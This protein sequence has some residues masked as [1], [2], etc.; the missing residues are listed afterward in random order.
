VVR[1]GTLPSVAALV[2]SLPILSLRNG[3]P[4][5]LTQ[6]PAVRT[7]SSAD[8]LTRV[9]YQR[10][11]TALDTGMTLGNLVPNARAWFL[12]FD[13]ELARR[14]R[15]RTL[16]ARLAV[17]PNRADS[18]TFVYWHASRTTRRARGFL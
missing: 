11:G 15:L 1:R 7:S 8:V 9:D 14:K 5:G 13:A 2:L 6:N 16:K 18:G 4:G 10:A 17:L 12:D 3:P